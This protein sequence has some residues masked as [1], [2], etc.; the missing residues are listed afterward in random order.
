MSKK[1]IPCVINAAYGDPSPAGLPISLGVPFPKGAL[2]DPAALAVRSPSG[3]LRPAAG[4]VLVRHADGSI[5]WCLVSFGAREAGEHE[6]V[7]HQ[8]KKSSKPKP[9]TEPK[10]V[11][12]REGGDWII[13]G[14]RLRLRVCESGPGVLGELVCDGHAY[15]AKPGDLRFCVDDAT[16]LHEGRRTVRVI[17][18]SGPRVRLRVEGEHRRPDGSRCLSYRL[19]IEVWAGW[20]ALRLDY[21]YFNLE[22]RAAAQHIKRIAMETAWSL[23]PRPQRHFLQQ[24]YGLFYVSR[25]VHNPAPVALVADFT[26]AGAHVE[27]PAMLLDDVD[28]PFYLHAPL[29]DAHPWLGVKDDAR[30]VYLQMQ[31]FAAAKPN[32]LTSEGNRLVAEAWPATAETLELPQGRSRRQTFT[33]AFIAAAAPEG[34]G[35]AKLSGAPTQKPQGVAAVLDAPIHEG[36]AS[37]APAWIAHCG[38]FGHDRVLPVGKHVRMEANLSGLVRLNMPSTKFDVGDTDS[39]YG[40]SYAWINQDLVPRL[41]GAPEIPRIFPR[42]HPTQTYLECHEPVWTNNEYDV[43][44]AFAAELMRTGRTDLWQTLRLAARHN[45]EVDFLHYSDHQWLHRATPAHSARH[46]TTGAYPSH[47]WTQGLL[48][49][50]CLT[51]DPDALEVACALGDKTIENFAEP[52]LRAVLWGFNREI[53]WSVLTLACLADV[54][55][56]PRFRPFLDE[57][58]DYL[59]KFDRGG[60]RGGINLSGGNDRQNLNRQIVGNFFGYGSMIEGMDIYADVT[61][62]KDAARWLAKLCHDLA[63]E[64]LNAAREGQ[65][66]GLNFSTALCIGYERTKDRR[67]VDLMSFLLDAAYWNRV[68]PDGDASVKPVAMIYR[69]L[70]RMLGHAWRHGLLDAHE[71]P[72]WRKLGKGKPRSGKATK[73]KQKKK[74]RGRKG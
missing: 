18:E 13:D 14:G 45:I 19:D 15:L 6:V 8:D 9:E 36:R 30:A 28:Y 34:D 11:L 51:G 68:G 44:H 53:G 66:P 38:E 12:R 49:Y 23:G 74:A 56:E 16:T 43:I 47:F 29:V 4:R 62:R 48:E 10:V 63:D 46:T 1:P 40:S 65:M 37:V 2:K 39:H 64:Q 57:M 25:H 59:M 60:Y 7:W 3:E 24:N 50:Y 22:P 20:P 42:G 35:T 70:P 71:Y 5:R 21:H 32:R 27:G 41:A 26:R 69:G 61:G 54:T 55:G 17:D 31:D 58:V 73:P 33:L 72:S 67:F 52:D